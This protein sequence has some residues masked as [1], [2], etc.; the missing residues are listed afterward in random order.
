M[1][2]PRVGHAI[3]YDTSG[4]RVV[5]F[6]GTSLG[7]WVLDTWIYRTSQPADVAPFGAGCAGS[8]GMPQLAAAPYTLP[9]L[10]DT[11][12]NVVQTIP[13]GEPGALFVSSIV[14]SLPLPLG[15]AGAPGCDLLVQPDV[16]EFRAAAAGKAEWALPV[17]NV[18]ALAGAMF[19]Q[20]A[21]VFDAA[22]NALGL[23]A[24]NGVVVTLGV[25]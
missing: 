25:R 12:R 18:P 9:W 2:G 7:S 16:V 8:A 3:A 13:T 10:G 21:F 6:G 15:F 1:P 14:S 5:T 4:R 24:S 22:A 11:M 17:P 23:A 19:W 20:Q